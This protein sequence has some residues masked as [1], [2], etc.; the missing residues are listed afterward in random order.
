VKEPSRPRPTLRSRAGRS[1]PAT[2]CLPPHKGESTLLPPGRV[3]RKREFHQTHALP[4][5]SDPGTGQ[6]SIGPLHSTPPP[7]RND[8][9]FCSRF[10]NAFD[11]P[12]Q[13]SFLIMFRIV[14][15][16]SG[17]RDPDTVRMEEVF[18]C[19][20]FPPRFTNPCFSKSAMSWRI[21]RGIPTVPSAPRPAKHPSILFASGRSRRV[22]LPSPASTEGN[23]D[24]TMVGFD[25]AH[26]KLTRMTQI[27]GGIL[28]IRNRKSKIPKPFVPFCKKSDS[29]EGNQV[30]KGSEATPGSN[31]ACF[32]C[33]DLAYSFHDAKGAR[34]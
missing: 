1:P 28:T 34:P 11:C 15:R 20:P 30:N 5:A 31:A 24:L 18:R 16:P 4:R 22:Y 13:I 10:S 3:L 21:L 12:P 33:N 23:K 7:S 8:Q 26:H 17:Q 9:M 32:R 19:D 6:H 14:A 27:A 2:A 29:T 25:C